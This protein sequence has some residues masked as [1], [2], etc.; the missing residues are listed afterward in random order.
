MFVSEEV[1]VGGAHAVV[2]MQQIAQWSSAHGGRLLVR[3]A[4]WMRLFPVIVVI[5]LRP[6]TAVGGAPATFVSEQTEV[7]ARPAVVKIKANLRASPSSKGDIVAVAEEG[8]VVQ[9]L[10]ETKHWYRIKTEEGIDAWIYKQLAVILQG[11]PRFQAEPPPAESPEAAAGVP[12]QATVEQPGPLM[13]PP[14]QEEQPTGTVISEPAFRGDQA[15]PVPS[16]EAPPQHGRSIADFQSLSAYLI[17]ALLVVSVAAI[18]LQLRAARQLK[19]AMREIDRLPR[20]PAPEPALSLGVSTPPTHPN[21]LQEAPAVGTSAPMGMSQAA[22]ISVRPHADVVQFPDLS[23]ALSPLERALLE[24]IHARGE[25][26]EGELTRTL[27][28]RGFPGVLVKAVIADIVRKTGAEGPPWVRVRYA[29]G[30]YAY[31]L[32][33]AGVPEQSDAHAGG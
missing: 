6:M 26:Q 2:M 29:Q 5:L 27:V 21:P 7:P 14:V 16:P 28:Q 12:R 17:G 33:L 30:R 22:G 19:R 15:Q 18:G 23:V 24:V 25:V 8:I 4:G 32:Q 9:L 31:Q 20:S 3:A 13:S 10:G 1:G 11:P